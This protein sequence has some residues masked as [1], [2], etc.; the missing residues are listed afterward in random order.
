MTAEASVATRSSTGGSFRYYVLKPGIILGI[1]LGVIGAIVCGEIVSHAW[2][3]NQDAAL[4]AGYSG[5]AVFFLAGIGA[6][7]G[8]WEWGWGRQEPTFEQEMEWA[9]KDQGL[10]RFFRF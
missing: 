5:W 1:I 8:I 10:W 6:F 3:G 2:D 7:N 9:G 4:V